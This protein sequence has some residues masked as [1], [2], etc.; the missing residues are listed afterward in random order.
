MNE[1]EKQ[2]IRR[3]LSARRLELGAEQAEAAARSAAARLLER[4]E[5]RAS[6]AVG[7]YWAHRGEISTAEIFQGLSAAGKEVF[8]PRIDPADDRLVFAAFEN[9]EDLVPGR[10][11]V[12]EPKSP[13]QR[14]IRDLP[15]LLV[16]GLA[17]DLA[18][19][20]IGWG[21]GYYDRVLRGYRGF[22]LALAYDFQVLAALPREA[23]DEG[24]QVLV[25]EARSIEAIQA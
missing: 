23:H 14:E 1:S 2:R 3:E 11:G 20:R 22:R 17:F 9:E 12:L 4:E 19:G 6:A 16:P 15:A 21:R 5:I 18:G 8:L 10:F 24:V 25:T 7:I 13:I